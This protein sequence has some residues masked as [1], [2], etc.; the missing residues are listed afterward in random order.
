MD[1]KVAKAGKYMSLLL[2]HQP[3][4]EYLDMDK[5]GWVSVQQLISRL[6]IT[7]SDLEDIV[8]ENNKQRF[9][10]NESKSKIRANQGH[11]IPVDLQL[12]ELTP[13]TILYHGT[14]TK[15][16]TSIYEKGLMKGNRQ[17][18]HLSHNLETATQ[19][20]SRHGTVHVLII[21]TKSMIEDGLKF[22]QSE[23]GVWLTDFVPIKYITK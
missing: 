3:E 13:P 22:Y 18:V 20:G 8:T 2:R 4:A 7:I 9:S 21:D 14:A 1:K 19:V 23:N 17:H 5:Y 15:F 10:F 6:D 16:L 11:S 12:S